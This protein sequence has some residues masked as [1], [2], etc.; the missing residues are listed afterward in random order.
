MVTVDLY[1]W[2]GGKLEELAL[3]QN[4]ARFPSRGDVLELNLGHWPYQF[5]EVDR[6][7]LAFDEEVVKVIVKEYIPPA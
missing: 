6:L 4:F 1:V 3:D 2:Q 5:V 7:L